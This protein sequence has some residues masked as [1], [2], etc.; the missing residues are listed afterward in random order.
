MAYSPQMLQDQLDRYRKLR[1]GQQ[2][3]APKWTDFQPQQLSYQKPQ[4]QEQTYR[5]IADTIMGADDEATAT[6]LIKAQNEFNYQQ[7]LQAQEQKKIAKQNQVKL[8]PAQ[9]GVGGP[10]PQGG[11]ANP[12]DW[13]KD[14]IP[15]VS[16][17]DYINAEGPLRTMQFHGMSYTVNAQVAPIFQAFLR[18]L[19]KM[20]YKPKS[21]G[22]HSERNI[23]GT[24]TP[25][26]H[27]HGLAIDI[28]PGINPIYYNSQGG[29]YALPP[30][31]GALAAKYGLSWGGNWQ[32]T[33][34]Y[35]HFSVPYGGRE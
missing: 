5:T 34:D 3:G 26:L 15:E 8:Q 2:P 33:K 1:D 4:G 20:G 7:M 10:I 25:S 24:N 12:Q 28:D 13:G 22:G 23:A 27:S 30:S 21:I 32:N 17:L 11:T 16:D 35:M 31:V 19:W 6:A 9:Q 14:R 18:D 29:K